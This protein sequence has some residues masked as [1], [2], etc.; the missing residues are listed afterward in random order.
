MLEGWGW[1]NYFPDLP[2]LYDWLPRNYW[3]RHPTNRCPNAMNPGVHERE[4]AKA[5]TQDK[6]LTKSI[7]STCMI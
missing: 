6:G 3:W 7:E 5:K 2:R 4:I 1:R